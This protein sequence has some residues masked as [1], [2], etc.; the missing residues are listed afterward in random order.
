VTEPLYLPA[1]QGELGSWL[2]YACLMRLSDVAERVSYAREIH[3][4]TSLSDMIQRR[5]DESKRGKEIEQYLLHTKDRFFNSLVVGVYGGDPQWHPF[6]V[7][8]RKSQHTDAVTQNED[9]VGYLELSGDEHLFALDG[10]HRLSGIR[11]AL[12]RAA[13]LGTERV[14]VLF[15]SHKKDAAG[16]KRTRSLFVAINKR[17]VPVQ[18]RDIIALDE[19]DLAAIITRQLVDD[20]R[21]FSRGQVDVDRFTA[22][23][24]V[25]APALTTIGSF[26]DVIRKSIRDVMAVDDKEQ[27]RKADRIRLS[28]ARIE[29]YRKLTLSYFETIAALDPQLTAALKAKDPGS[30]FP[31]G[32]TR[33]SPRL[34]FRPI[35]FTIVTD[36]LA[37]IR[38]TNS[39]STTLRLAKSI[40]LLMTSQ[41]FVDIVYDPRRNRMTTTNAGLAS[42]LLVYMLGGEA[43][44]KLKE[45][46]AKERG[47]PVNRSRL[48]K[49]LV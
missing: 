12:D 16:L 26:Y 2:Y 7:S 14:S 1:L 21:W 41:P 6:D 34:L 49:R 38:K 29:H 25:N 23:I 13:S 30:L 32:R 17:A 47:V 43:D 48:P 44:E 27:L 18:K 11:Q 39:L 4:N 40:P 42:R 28:D 3:Q 36:A 10:Q 20:H 5:L 37:R 19:V 9:V 15:V 31:A 22:S 33:E 45:A 24:P 35:G 8:T 46:Y